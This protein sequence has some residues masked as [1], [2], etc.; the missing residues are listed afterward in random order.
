MNDEN[1]DSAACYRKALDL[2]ARRSHFRAELRHRLERR[3]FSAQAVET[4]LLRVAEDGYLDDHATARA[5]IEERLRRGP[6]GR[7][8]LRSELQRR[9]APEDAIDAA[10]AE[11]TPDDDVEPAR[12]AAARW[13]RTHRGG[14][15]ALARHLDRK[16]FSRRA[17]LTILEESETP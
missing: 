17:I 3:D 2:L 11:M 5:F 4:A 14:P 6:E 8:R 13:R 12:T 1:D 15:E 9:G 7:A 16:G 10:L